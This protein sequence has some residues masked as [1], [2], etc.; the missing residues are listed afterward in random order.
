MNIYLHP[1]TCMHKYNACMHVHAS[2]NVDIGSL[3]ILDGMLQVAFLIISNCG[4]WESGKPFITMEKISKKIEEP[5]F[6]KSIRKVFIILYI[7]F[8]DLLIY[9]QHD[10]F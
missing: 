9:C 5:I 1:H 8:A 3:I 6:E 2:W 7:V 4:Q 10:I